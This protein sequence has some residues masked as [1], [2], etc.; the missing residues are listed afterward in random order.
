M[1]GWCRF[2]GVKQFL[3]LQK[4]MRVSEPGPLKDFGRDVANA[5]VPGFLLIK[6]LSTDRYAYNF[7]HLLSETAAHLME[8]GQWC[9]S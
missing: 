8:I 9:T 4:H 2:E 7:K 6:P 3:A 5:G 1:D